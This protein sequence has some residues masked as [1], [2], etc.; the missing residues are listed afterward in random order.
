VGKNRKGLFGHAK[1]DEKE[2]HVRP[3]HFYSLAK[4][5]SIQNI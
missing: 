2:N 1:R 5:L 4:H 3:T